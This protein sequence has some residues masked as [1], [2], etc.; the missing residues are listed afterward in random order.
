M[1]GRYSTMNQATD[2]RR[3]G[4][5]LSVLI[6][7]VVTWIAGRPAQRRI[8]GPVDDGAPPAWASNRDDRADAPL[9]MGAASPNPRVLRRGAIFSA[10]NAALPVTD[11]HGLAGRSAELDR[12]IEAVVRQHKHA[13][14]FG[15]RGSGKTSLVRVFGDLA[16][17]AG[18]VALYAS[19]SSDASFED[20]FRPFLTE[21]PIGTS[22]K[23][24]ADRLAVAGFDVAQFANLLVAEIRPRTLLIIDEFDRIESAKV[25]QDVAA[26]LKL[27][28]D[29]LSPVQIVLVGIAGDV[30]GLIA[31]HPSLR[32]HL[33]TQQVKPIAGQELAALLHGCAGQV[34]LSVDAAAM[35][36]IVAAAMGS[37]YHARLFG[38]HAALAADAAGHDEISDAD[39]ATGL[40]NSLS[41][42]ADVA[43]NT[44]E[45]FAQA[46]D[47]HDDVRR[48]VALAGV[49]AAQLSV[50]STDRLTAIGTD[51]FGSED[52]ARRAATEALARLE[53][54]LG[55]IAG[56][57][58]HQFEDSLAPQ[59][60]VLMAKNAVARP[61]AGTA[62]RSAEMR[63]LLQGV[64]GL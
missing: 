6:R 49:V 60:L 1:S 42:W 21:L 25:K 13:I 32:R 15:A 19:A 30:D 35:D 50:V 10:F 4:G 7:S 59:F 63:S 5:R 16:D 53:P 54:A 40:A 31:A 55:A 24:Q 37:P 23:A 41:E 45:V 33:T 11:R 18:C 28:T 17:E 44:H 27:L 12:L 36:S 47:T 64:A 51:L 29:I 8:P 56:G 9:S 34:G 26:L 52:E 39:V 20:L 2:D 57:R 38:M 14:I 43:G 3:G 62:N 61:A 46:L 22:G 48:M 58:D